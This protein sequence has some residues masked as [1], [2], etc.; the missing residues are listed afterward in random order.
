M[1][2]SPIADDPE[3]IVEVQALEAAIDASDAD[4]RAA[5]HEQVRAWL[6][7]LAEGDFHAPAPLPC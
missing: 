1:S 7:R 4:P 5:A 3:S 6:Q 2:T